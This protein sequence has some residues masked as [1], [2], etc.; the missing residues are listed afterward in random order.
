LNHTGELKAPYWV[1]SRWRARPRRRRRRPCSRSSCP[2]HRRTRGWCAR[3]G[4]ELADA[5]L[6]LL[7][8][9]VRPALR[10]YLETAMSVASCDQL[11]GISA[12]RISNTIEPSGLVMTLSRRSQLT[13]FLS[14]VRSRKKARSLLRSAREGSDSDAHRQG[15]N[16]RLEVTAPLR[17]CTWAEGGSGTPTSKLPCSARPEERDL[18][19]E[20]RTKLERGG[21]AG[22]SDRGPRSSALA[23]PPARSS[24][25]SQS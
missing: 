1:T 3:P 16:P 9:A 5:G 10:K 12:P 20:E 23:A 22:L 25:A 15:R 11:S 18:K 13:F 7:R 24:R 19:E 4:D 14:P 2:A 21:R 6:A 17:P 8:V